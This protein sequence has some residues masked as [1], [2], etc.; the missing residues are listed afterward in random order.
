MCEEHEVHGEE[1]ES[2]RLGRQREV[3][4]QRGLASRERARETGH[5]LESVEV[6]ASLDAR[7]T[8]A[9]SDAF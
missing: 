5:Y 3:F 8:K 9:R 1:R 6:L 4:I 2:D 7:L